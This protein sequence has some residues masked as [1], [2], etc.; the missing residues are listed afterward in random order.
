MI[1]RAVLFT[2]EGLCLFRFHCIRDGGGWLI[3]V[4]AAL[5]GRC[6]ADLDSSVHTFPEVGGL[7]C[8]H[9]GG[10]TVFRFHDNVAM[11]LM[12]FVLFFFFRFVCFFSCCLSVYLL[13]PNQAVTVFFQFYIA[14]SQDSSS[15]PDMALNHP[16]ATQGRERDRRRN[17]HTN[18][19]RP[20]HDNALFFLFSILR[21]TASV[22][23]MM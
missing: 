1:W 3:D 22:H 14:L 7:I 4:S 6:L 15:L 21:F 5:E 23:A 11:F 16:R 12:M 8:S 9:I 2:S 19:R 17:R 10:L 18:W 20:R 13:L